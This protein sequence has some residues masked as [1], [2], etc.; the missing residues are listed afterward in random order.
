MNNLGIVISGLPASGKTTFGTQLAARLGIECLDKDTFLE[1]LFGQ[2]ESGDPQRRQH[3]STIS[4]GH[5]EAA[6][7]GLDQVVLVSHWRPP[8]AQGP[9]GTPTAWLSD[10]FRIVVEV[11]CTCP[12]RTALTRFV[13]RQRHPG[14]GDQHRDRAELLAWLQTYEAKLPLETGHLINVDTT[15]VGSVDN[16]ARQVLAL[17]KEPGS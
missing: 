17:A 14:H 12:A 11:C 7:R 10:T 8:A 13:Q 6:A 2:H 3:L 16:V 9:S 4:N 1:Q 5:F 15:V